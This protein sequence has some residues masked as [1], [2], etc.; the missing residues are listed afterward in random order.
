MKTV[1]LASLL[2]TG[3]LSYSAH[4]QAPR[5]PSIRFPDNNARVTT[6]QITVSG[7]TTP[8]SG[9]TSVQYTIDGNGPFVATR[10][11]T[12]N[13]NNWQAPVSLTVG[14]NQFR[15]W[16]NGPGGASTSNSAN[17]FLV[18]TNPIAIA[19]DGRGAVEP[20]YNRPRRPGKRA[21][22]CGLERE[23]H[24]KRPETD[25]PHAVEYA[26]DRHVRRQSVYQQY[27]SGRV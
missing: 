15:V 20:N 21:I 3:L 10:L 25:F 23:R 18:V 6:N 26:V 13:W 9:V 12:N 14:S 19:I 17:Y 22:F 11:N 24:L 8:G 4:A 1:I 16:D 2:I 7:N 5:R 27:S